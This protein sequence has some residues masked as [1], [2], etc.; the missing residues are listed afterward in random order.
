[1]SNKLPDRNPDVIKRWQLT[2]LTEN[3]NK[4]YTLKWWK[5]EEIAEI[6][7][8]RVGQPCARPAIKENIN[9]RKFEKLCA[10][11]EKPKEEG[12]YK[13][14]KTGVQQVIKADTSGLSDKLVKRIT[15]IFQAANESIHT[16]LNTNISDLAPEQI[17]KGKLQLA[18]LQK[19]FTK[20]EEH[21]HYTKNMYSDELIEQA[22]IYYEYIPSKLPYKID[23]LSVAVNLAK[24]L[25][26]EEDKLQQLEAAVTSYSISTGGGNILDQLGCSIEPA[27]DGEYDKIVKY[28][29]DTKK[30]YQYR[31]MNVQEVWKL[32]VP[33]EKKE[34]ASFPVQS[35]IKL[36]WHGTADRNVRHICRTSLI[37]PKYHSNGSLFGRGIYFADVATKSLNYAG[38]GNEKYLFLADVILG[39]QYNTSKFIDAGES[40]PKGYDSLFAEAGKHIKGVWAG[41]LEHNE[42]VIFQKQ[43]KALRYLVVIK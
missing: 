33:Q 9:Q 37:I 8:G 2:N 17:A 12:T 30:H 40:I 1:M 28:F 15:A 32:E 6:T 21:M 20:F 4:W 34:F 18:E 39:K 16:Y 27:N 13:E 25:A 35:N 41:K 38:G 31:R 3:N 29:N 5:A 7:Y 43:Q 19:T 22:R 36:L 26:N 42:F 23:A 24:N 14:I 10:D 11:R